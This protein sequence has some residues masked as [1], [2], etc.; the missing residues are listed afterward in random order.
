MIVVFVG[1]LAI[2]F[3]YFRNI[4]VVVNFLFL[5]GIVT[6]IIGVFLM[7]RISQPGVRRLGLY[8]RYPNNPPIDN[9]QRSVKTGL[10]IIAAGVIMMLM[11]VVIWEISNM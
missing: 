7:T 4:L 10:L 6:F 3:L 1:I 9:K 2:L 5:A 11:S 8:A